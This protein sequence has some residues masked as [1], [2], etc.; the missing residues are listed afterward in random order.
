MAQV[1]HSHIGKG[2]SP[3]VNWALVYPQLNLD[4][5][6]PD[7]DGGFKEILKTVV[8]LLVHSSLTV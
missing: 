1:A 6:P 7:L 3:E 8:I 5:L 2:Y 4:C